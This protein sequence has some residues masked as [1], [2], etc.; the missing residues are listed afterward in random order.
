[1]SRIAAEPDQGGRCPPRSQPLAGASR[2]LAEAALM[3][4]VAAGDAEAFEASTTATRGRCTPILVAQ[5]GRSGE[6]EDVCQDAFLA[7]W[8]HAS[9]FDPAARGRARLADRD[10]P[11]PGDQQAS[12]PGPSGPG[13]GGCPRGR[14]PRAVPR[15]PSRAPGA[16]RAEAARLRRLLDD[17]P[18]RAARR[19]AARPLRRRL[20]ARDRRGHGPAPR[21]RQEPAAPGAR[22][23]APDGGRPEAPAAAATPAPAR[24]RARHEPPRSPTAPP[25]AR[26]RRARRR[27]PPAGRGAGS[28]AGPR[29]SAQSA[30]GRRRRR[31][32]ARSRRPWHRSAA[33]AGPSPARGGA[34]EARR[35]GSR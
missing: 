32:G 25:A 26:Q 13:R 2:T 14:G 8:R 31:R 10:R 12:R 1:M 19:A 22:P 33:G 35:S 3:D 20:P 18:G 27:G 34:A 5:L 21:D 30:A 6:A 4:R 29:R 15:T 11:Q 23:G 16:D 7:L 24:P 9:R 17:G 28:P